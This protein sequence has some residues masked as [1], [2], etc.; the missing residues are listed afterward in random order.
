MVAVFK[1]LLSVFL[2]S[3]AASEPEESLQL[4]Q[5]AAAKKD[6]QVKKHHKREHADDAS[7]DFVC[8]LCA[9]SE[10]DFDPTGKAGK[11]ERINQ[12]A[13]V[14]AQRC[15]KRQNRKGVIRG[16]CPAPP[17]ECKMCGS[18]YEFKPGNLD[19]RCERF[20]T[21]ASVQKGTDTC[22]K[23]KRKKKVQQG[24][25][26]KILI[27]TT[28]NVCLGA[29]DESNAEIQVTAGMCIE[30]I[31][32]THKSGSVSCAGPHHAANFGC[33]DL[34]AL[35]ITQH[36]SRSVLGPLDGTEGYRHAGHSHGHWYYMSGVNRNT[37]QVKFKFG[38]PIKAEGELLDLWYGEDLTDESE[39][40]NWGQACYDVKVIPTAA[41]ACD[42]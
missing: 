32:I 38:T 12:R 17:V 8:D 11:C 35:A 41:E 16:C 3:V 39:G 27:M 5:V 7:D 14:N 23:I 30:E 21:R 4:L 24:C 10:H 18:G 29:R 13:Q 9:D 33:F 2:A 25:C 40:D 31:Q 6:S 1:P 20:A 15:E 26:E 19:G 22:D 42:L 28:A 36:G 37:P 34:I